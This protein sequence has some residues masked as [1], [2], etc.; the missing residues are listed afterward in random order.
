MSCR[1]TWRQPWYFDEDQRHINALVYVAIKGGCHAV[2]QLPMLCIDILSLQGHISQRLS[3]YP[4]SEIFLKR[5][6]LR[7]T[8]CCVNSV[9]VH[10]HQHI[11]LKIVIILGNYKIHFSGEKYP[12][13]MI[14]EASL[15]TVYIQHRI[16]LYIHKHSAL[17]HVRFF[18]IPW[19]VTRQAPLSMGFSRQ[20]HWSG[21]P[22]PSPGN[23]PNPGIKPRSL[24]LPAESLPSKPP[25]SPYMCVCVYTHTHKAQLE[26]IPWN[27]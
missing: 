21:L 10:L 2:L 7:K 22:C 14:W 9:S 20:E 15:S 11:H 24:A 1:L 19:T 4:E 18:V 5:Q 16:Y 3:F 8:F 23:L 12:Q 13:G 27:I 26:W 25:G 6:M 17:S